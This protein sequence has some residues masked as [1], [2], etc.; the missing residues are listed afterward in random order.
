MKHRA[1]TEL[2]YT[3]EY[4]YE[5]ERAHA[6]DAAFDLRAG[7]GGYLDTHRM[8]RKGHTFNTG[9]RV[10]CPPGIALLVLPRSGLATKHGLTLANSPG[11]I[12]PGYRG[13]IKVHLY[14]LEGFHEYYVES[15]DRIAQLLPI[16]THQHLTPVITT[17][18]NKG[19]RGEHGF[20]STGR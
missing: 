14:L 19:E 5:L 6:S 2:R 17:Q 16:A 3:S 8:V 13:E 7:E 9:I 20:G 12:D 18:L 10:E 4:G 15:G 1:T 11:L